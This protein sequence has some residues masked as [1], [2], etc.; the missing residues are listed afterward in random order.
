[1]GTVTCKNKTQMRILGPKMPRN[2]IQM[3]KDQ[4]PTSHH[5]RFAPFGFGAFVN[6][7]SLVQWP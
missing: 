1:M 5:L 7:L 4:L 2:V 3:G 6:F